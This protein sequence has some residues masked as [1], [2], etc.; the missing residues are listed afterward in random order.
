MSMPSVLELPHRRVLLVVED[1][2]LAELLLDSLKDAG[3]EGELADDERKL[4]RAL[5]SRSFDAAIVDMDT[6]ARNGA[7]L[8]QSIRSRAPATTVIAL[9]PCGGLGSGLAT[10]HYHLAIEKP[11]RLHT[12]LAALSVSNPISAN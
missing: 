1:L 6:R 9:L 2:A 5:D 11:A 12:I 7:E 10:P 8:I 3:H 4:D